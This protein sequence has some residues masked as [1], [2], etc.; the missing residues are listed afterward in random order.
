MGDKVKL[1]YYH[2]EDA[3]KRSFPTL[4]IIEEYDIKDK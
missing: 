1:R 3:H 4:G 2:Y